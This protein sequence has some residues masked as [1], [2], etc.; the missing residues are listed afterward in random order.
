MLFCSRTESEVFE[1]SGQRH[2]ASV[3]NA[4]STTSIS[5]SKNR[6]SARRL[7]ENTSTWREVKR[8]PHKILVAAQ[9]IARVIGRGGQNINAIR[10]SS[11][12]HIE[13][14]KQ[15]KGQT[16]RLITI[17]GSLD[18]I[19]QAVL[20]INGLIN[21]PD[22]LVRDIIIKV[23]SKDR[24][25]LEA[26]AQSRSATQCGTSH[27]KLLSSAKTDK[28]SSFPEISLWVPNSSSVGVHGVCGADSSKGSARS[29]PSAGG[30]LSSIENDAVSSIKYQYSQATEKSSVNTMAS[31]GDSV[32]EYSPFAT[33]NVW[34]QK[35]AAQ[36]QQQKMN[37]ASVAAAGLNSIATAVMSEEH[38][39]VPIYRPGMLSTTN[40]A[41]A[42]NTTTSAD[43]SSSMKKDSDLEPSKWYGFRSDGVS[44][45]TCMACPPHSIPQTDG[46]SQRLNQSRKSTTPS[47]F[48]IDN[49]DSENNGRHSAGASAD[50]FPPVSVPRPASATAAIN[51]SSEMS[52]LQ[53]PPPGLSGENVD[54]AM[55]RGGL[56]FPTPIGG[57]RKIKGP[58][59]CS[60]GVANMFT[61]SEKWGTPASFENGYNDIEKNDWS[62]SLSGLS[63]DLAHLQSA[64]ISHGIAAAHAAAEFEMMGSGSSKFEPDVFQQA[65]MLASVMNP[66]SSTTGSF[67]PSGGHMITPQHMGF[68]TPAQFAA[69]APGPP[70]ECLQPP[71]LHRGGVGMPF[72]PHHSFPLQSLM[73]SA[74]IDAWDQ[75]QGVRTP[76]PAQNYDWKMMNGSGA[77]TT[78]LNEQGQMPPHSHLSWDGYSPMAL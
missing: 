29:T 63:A 8:Q 77:P 11:G 6:S 16:D 53:E 13:V 41:A 25:A 27:L 42:S 65:V 7:D 5:R 67:V 32:A 20:M 39:K 72:I 57:E 43:S 71:P 1:K 52:C 37:F 66:Q 18:A 9:A 59:G 31:A 48:D 73:H 74:L 75:Q 44:P 69:S 12:A 35:A 51:T 68:M 33:P 76:N 56:P 23:K 4:S 28:S 34:A 14:E 50:Y 10:E 22:A 3:T 30:C 45:F 60:S 62:T 54:S 61:S 70:P 26:Y 21:E 55:L 19:K 2:L 17:R 24:R 49:F 15:Q 58:I 47:S 38:S 36:Q 78:P 64:A 46:D 40:A